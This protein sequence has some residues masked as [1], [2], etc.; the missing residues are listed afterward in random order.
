MREFPP[1]IVD[2]WTAH[3]ILTSQIPEHP[4]FVLIVL[5]KEGGVLLVNSPERGWSI[6]GGRTEGYE[7]A[8]EAGMREL[9]EEAG[10]LVEELLPLGYYTLRKEVCHS[11]GVIFVARPREIRGGELPVKWVAWEDLEREYYSWNE[12]FEAVF[13]HAREIC[14][15]N[16]EGFDG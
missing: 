7:S 14:R 3:F 8:W 5:C 16:L 12:L 9:K 15:R 10:V 1:A 13:W 11:T 2:G 6:P 4:E